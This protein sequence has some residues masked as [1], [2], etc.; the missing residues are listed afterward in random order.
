MKKQVISLGGGCDIAMN[1]ERLGFKKESLFFDWLWNLNSGL[2]AVNNIIKNDFYGVIKP[3][4]YEK[5]L[6]YRFHSQEVVVYKHYPLIAHLHSNPLNNE[7]D[8]DTLVRRINRTKELFS[9][10]DRHLVFIYYLNYEEFKRCMNEPSLDY[11]ISKI[12]REGNEFVEI[13][14]GKYPYKKF[15]LVLVVQTDFSDRKRIKKKIWNAK[16]K[17]HDLITHLD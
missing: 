3:D 16:N 5:R 10:P 1:L 12:I 13:F 9:V 2:E 7:Y 6:H 17:S 8:H 4:S 11:A 14:T 15:R